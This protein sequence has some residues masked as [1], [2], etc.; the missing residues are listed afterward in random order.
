MRDVDGDSLFLLNLMSSG[1]AVRAVDGDS[2]C[3]LNLV[4][5]HRQGRCCRWLP[6]LGNLTN[7]YGYSVDR[8]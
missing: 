7:K 4:D 6:E 8:C 5:E 2:L 1:A 3:F